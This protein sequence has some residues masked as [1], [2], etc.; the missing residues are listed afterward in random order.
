MPLRYHWQRGSPS[1]GRPLF[2]LACDI[3]TDSSINSADS[4]RLKVAV[5][6]QMTFTFKGVEGLLSLVNRN[7]RIELEKINGD[8]G[9]ETTSNMAHDEKTLPE[10]LNPAV[11]EVHDSTQ[12]IGENSAKDDEPSDI[13]SGEDLKEDS[14]RRYHSSARREN[15]ADDGSES[16]TLDSKQDSHDDAYA[17]LEKGLSLIADQKYFEAIGL[18]MAVKDSVSAFQGATSQKYQIYLSAARNIGILYWLNG[19]MDLSLQTLS[20]ALTLQKE[21]AR[22]GDLD[23]LL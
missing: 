16:Q 7:E 13:G 17:T 4:R 12:R 23:F 14:G 21:R 5:L 11:T 19:N 10:I 6:P 20:D 1:K 15:N 8:G 22:K 18:L 3:L 9:Y 2:D